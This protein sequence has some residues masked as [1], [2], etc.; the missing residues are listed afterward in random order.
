MP[1][2]PPASSHPSSQISYSPL[3]GPCSDAARGK[4]AR[5][6]CK[7]FLTDCQS[8]AEGTSNCATRCAR[9]FSGAEQATCERDCNLARCRDYPPY[10]TCVAANTLANV[11]ACMQKKCRDEAVDCLARRCN[12]Q[13]SGVSLVKA[14]E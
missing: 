11:L 1:K 12:I 4:L 8:D 2:T 14:T 3:S 6:L 7:P 10:D 13:A 9:Y 5:K